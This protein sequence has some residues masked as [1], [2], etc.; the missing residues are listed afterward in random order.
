[1]KLDEDVRPPTVLP[2]EVQAKLD[3]RE[4]MT[5]VCPAGE[6]VRDRKTGRQ[7]VFCKIEDDSLTL[8]ES[9]IAVACFCCHE[10]TECPSWQADRDNDPVVE[11]QRQA[12]AQ[13]KQD[14]LTERQVETGMRVDDREERDF[15]EW[16]EEEV[17]LQNDP[18]YDTDQGHDKS[19]LLLPPGY[20]AGLGEGSTD[21]GDA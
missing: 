4:P 16:V 21:D 7:G 19:E 17:A 9:A 8:A 11:R 1:M 14:R 18:N 20:E 3:R 2:P 13:R 12:K 6:P 15:A 10:Y 5:V